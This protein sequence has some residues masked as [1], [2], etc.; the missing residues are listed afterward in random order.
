[1]AL[2]P[3]TGGIFTIDLVHASKTTT[4]ATDSVSGESSEP[5]QPRT[6]RLWDRKTDG[7]FPETKELKN[8][9]RNIIQPDRDLGHIDR[10]L[11]KTQEKDQVA[12]SLSKTDVEEKSPVPSRLAISENSVDAGGASDTVDQSPAAAMK[13]EKDSQTC[14]DCR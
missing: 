12:Q 4:A 9:V 13:G 2:V 7:G 10:S 14:E 11:K 5:R 1:M 8:R 6:T 3:V